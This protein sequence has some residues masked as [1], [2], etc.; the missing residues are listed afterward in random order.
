LVLAVLAGQ[1]KR[2]SVTG[3]LGLLVV[4]QLL[5]RIVVRVVVLLVLLGLQ[6]DQTLLLVVQV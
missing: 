3:T 4:R 1:A 6:A 5:V 2:L